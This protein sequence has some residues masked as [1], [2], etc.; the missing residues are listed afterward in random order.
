MIT[1]KFKKGYI[2]FKLLVIIGLSVDSKLFGQLYNDD[3]AI[4]ANGL[5]ENNLREG[6]WVFYYPSGQISSIERYRRDQLHG[7]AKYFDFEGN[8]YQ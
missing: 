7:N 5:W 3:G 1:F 2:I 8:Y 6:E 4:K